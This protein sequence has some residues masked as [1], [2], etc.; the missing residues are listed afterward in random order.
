MWEGRRWTNNLVLASLDFNRQAH[1]IIVIVS[2]LF[3]KKL[4]ARILPLAA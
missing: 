1:N 4:C 3:T 2:V